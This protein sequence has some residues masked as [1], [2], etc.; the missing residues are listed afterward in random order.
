M[1]ARNEHFFERIFAR[2]FCQCKGARSGVVSP[3]DIL[4]FPL[5]FLGFAR[6]WQINAGSFFVWKIASQFG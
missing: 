1:W 6:T 5:N 2:F 4:P 3:G